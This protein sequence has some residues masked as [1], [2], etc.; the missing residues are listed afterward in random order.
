[1]RKDLARAATR[2]VIVVPAT[3]GAAEGTRVRATSN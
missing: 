3:M 1:M 2:S